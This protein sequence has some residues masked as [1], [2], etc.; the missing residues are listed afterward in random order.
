MRDVMAQYG[1]S[2]WRESVFQIHTQSLQL[3]HEVGS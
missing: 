3:E 1:V 2:R